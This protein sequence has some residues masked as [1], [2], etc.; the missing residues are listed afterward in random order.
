MYL[1]GEPLLLRPL[2]GFGCNCRNSITGLPQTNVAWPDDPKKNDSFPET[3]G[4]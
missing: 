1:T 2:T 4:V 3:P